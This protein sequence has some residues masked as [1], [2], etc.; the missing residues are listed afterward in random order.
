MRLLRQSI[1]RIG[2][3]WTAVR[4]FPIVGIGASAGGLDAFKA[5]LA[6]TPP[7]TGM[8][9]V[10]IQHL[11][12]LHAS[13]MAELRRATQRCPSRGRP[14]VPDRAEPCLSHPSGRLARRRRGKLHLSEPAERHGARLAFDFFLR[15]LA[16]DCGER[17][18]CVVLSGTGTD[19]SEGLKAVKKGAAS[20]SS[21]TLRRR[22]SMACR[23]AQSRPDRQI[24]PYLS[25][26]SRRAHQSRQR[27][28]RSALRREIGRQWRN[29]KR[30]LEILD[31][32]RQKT[33]QDFS[34]YKTGTLERRIER[35]MAMAGIADAARYVE[36]LRSDPAE[37]DSLGH[38]LLI[39]VT[40]FFR[41]SAAFE[42]LA[43]SV[44]PD[45][46]S[47]QPLDRPLR[48]WVPGCS[49]GEEV[50]SLT[51]LFLEAIEASK[52]NIKLQVFASDV[53]ARSVA[54]ARAGLY[55][56]ET[57][58][59]SGRDAPGPFFFEGR[60]GIP[61]SARFARNRGVHG[62]GPARR[63]AVLA[64]RSH[65]LPEPFDLSAAQRPRA[66]PFAVSFRSAC[67]R[68]AFSGRSETVGNSRSASNRSTKSKGSTAIY[69]A[70]R[71]GDVDFR[72]STTLRERLAPAAA[73][74][75]PENGN[76]R[77]F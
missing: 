5:L 68:R 26:D 76:P 35:R 59:P 56:P 40:E 53:D 55:G 77:Q 37:L 64:A 1:W 45:M 27:H 3:G 50:Y 62:P 8:A 30:F 19:G 63:P 44:I 72:A 54:F 13:L 73:P 28:S 7:D 65:F 23:K 69:S 18:I 48:I 49:T 38:D 21:R 51:M 16:E 42:A 61:G 12:P 11:D 60:H 14:R 58:A 36:R 71:P 29:R 33:H 31:L 4:R 67:G 17:A 41:D 70:C 43:A 22:R 32:V 25:Q 74:A 2:T 6:A 10:L 34:L 47:E 52:H 75:L 57:A 15:S 20:S 39:N 46:V 66:N 9:F 24:A